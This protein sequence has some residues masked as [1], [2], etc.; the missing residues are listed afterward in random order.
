MLKHWNLRAFGLVFFA[1]VAAS[2]CATSTD[3]PPPVAHDQDDDKASYIIGAGDQLQVFVWRN[4]DLT[5]SVRVRPDG[6]ISV[7]LIPDLP[8]AGKTPSDVAKDIEA[9]LGEYVKSPNV[10]VMVAD[11]VG[12]LDQM[13]RVVG[14]AGKPQAI[15]YRRGLTVLDVIISVG[16][17]TEFAAGNRTTVARRIDGKQEAFRVRLDDLLK[18]GDI[19]ANVEMAPGD[20]I[21]IPQSWF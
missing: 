10:T 7:P 14:E 15:P 21:I 12:P 20:I 18:D 1:A 2:G 16:G 8:V 4:P 9:K 5:T 13:V 19:S 6:R 11:F 17:L 3:A